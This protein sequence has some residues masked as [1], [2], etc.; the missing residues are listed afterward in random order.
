MEKKNNFIGLKF[1]KLTVI[2]CDGKRRYRD[3]FL[4]VCEC[5]NT[6]K[7]VVK[8][9][10]RRG[11]TKSCGCDFPNGSLGANLSKEEYFEHTRKRLKKKILIKNECWEWQGQLNN[12]GYAFASWGQAEEKKK[13][14]LHRVAYA[15]W[16]EEVPR[17]LC[18]LHKCDNPKCINPEHLYLGTKKDNTRDI[19]N[20]NRFNPARGEKCGMS[21]LKSEEILEIRDLR[22]K[23][24]TLN[25]ISHKFDVTYENIHAICK[26]RTWRHI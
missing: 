1:G 5:G 24:M 17:G 3:T 25:Q 11:K 7:N 12:H 4:C 26:R 9:G 14:V 6:R 13:T 22:E 21:K 10:L 8:E 16:I 2:E 19:K 20:R 18:V 15:I 23:G